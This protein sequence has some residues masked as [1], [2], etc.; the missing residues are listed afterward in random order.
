MLFALLGVAAFS[1]SLPATA[2]ALTGFGPWTST[3]LRGTFAG[4]LAAVCLVAMRAP[5]PRRSD[6][7]GLLVVAA[8]CVVGFPLLTSLALTTSSTSH[9]VIVIGV[10]PLATAAFSS[11]STGR[12]QSRAF[13]LAALAGAAVVVGF[14]LSQ[15]HGLPTTGDLYLVAA[16][17]VCG[18]GYAE[19]GRLSA[20]M[21]GWQVIAWG[22]VAGLPSMAVVSALA[23]E[24]EPMRL[25]AK[26]VFGLAYVTLISQFGGFVVWYRGMALV[27]V[28]K[29]SQLQLAQPLMTLCWSAT[30][31]G[32]RVPPL[33]PVAAVLVLGCVVATQRSGR[34][35]APAAPVPAD[36]DGGACHGPLESMRG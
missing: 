22:L 4:L 23:L 8:G 12:R 21:P 15:N 1:F 35:A 36:L 25:T 24:A 17:L 6:W 34:R 31:L 32:E 16:V 29:A 9:S 3:G 33:A 27:G 11:W 14:A 30:L 10:L 2:W 28:A 7:R 13:W 26:S 18:A 20:H 5:L 19:G